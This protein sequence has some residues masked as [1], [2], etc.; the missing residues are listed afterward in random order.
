M[1]DKIFGRLTVIRENPIRTK[2]RSKNRYGGN[3]ANN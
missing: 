2:S 1:I 3:N